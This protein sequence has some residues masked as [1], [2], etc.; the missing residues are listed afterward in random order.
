[1]GSFGIMKKEDEMYLGS[2][3]L[4]DIVSAEETHNELPESK[5]YSTI[6]RFTDSTGIVFEI[7]LIH[8]D[9]RFVWKTK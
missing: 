6:L 8:K 1:M 3:T 4:H 5:L 7:D 2:L 9:K